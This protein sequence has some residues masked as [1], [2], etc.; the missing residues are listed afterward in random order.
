MVK[1]N[2]VRTAYTRFSRTILNVTPGEIMVHVV[3]GNDFVKL[4]LK[5]IAK[6]KRGKYSA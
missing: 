4:C 3:H 1:A 5:Y 6:H 2:L